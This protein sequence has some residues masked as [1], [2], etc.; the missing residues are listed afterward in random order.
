[1]IAGTPP[2]K[3]EV[4]SINAGFILGHPAGKLTSKEEQFTEEESMLYHTSAGFSQT[5]TKVIEAGMRTD[6]VARMNM[7][8]GFLTGQ[9]ED[10]L[11]LV[12]SSDI[13]LA[14]ANGVKDPFVNHD[15]IN[16]QV[17]YKNL[18]ENKRFK[19]AHVPFWE[20]PE[21]FNIFLERFYNDVCKENK[22]WKI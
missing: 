15:Y 1:M 17:K 9:G 7:I 20:L 21:E 22:E 5:F 18:Y 3:P 8:K 6:G 13:P 11:H 12:E 19:C 10:E 4:D 2:I 16:N 14:I